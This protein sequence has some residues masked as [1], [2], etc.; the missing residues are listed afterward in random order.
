VLHTTDAELIE[1]VRS[2]FAAESLSDPSG[3]VVVTEPGG[4]DEAASREIAA[5]LASLPCIVLAAGHGTAVAHVDA[6]GEV[7]VA[8]IDD[9][10]RV[11]ERAPLAATAFTLLLRASPDTEA[12]DLAV[13]RGLVAES[14]TYS[15]LQ[16]GP[17]FAAWRA[18]RPR[19]DPSA[20]T[21][22]AVR[23]ERTGARLELVLDRP[24]VRNA[25]DRRLRDGML[26]GLAIASADTTVTDV[27]VRG[28]GPSFCSGGDL[29][30][31]GSFGDPASAHLVRLTASIGR[32]IHALRDRI[33]FEV[34]GPCAG[35]GVELPAFA[36]RVT[37]A[38]DYEA[39]LP[40]V[41][42]GLVP[43][44][45]GTVSLPRRIGR[46]R[47]ALLA[48]SSARIDAATALR[49]GLVDAIG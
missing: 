47:T 44:A 6:A 26:E 9:V 5:A 45:G 34:H 4:I 2:P 46:H 35:S 20:G 32:T 42:L 33:R 17:E 13:D 31:F 40:E 39:V 25:L 10:L 38:A 48:L 12:R 15:M 18:S 30:E 19:R 22:P 41:A 3:M 1:L 24:E 21:G 8:G 11:V 37:A 23:V 29:D 36:H 7:G 49:W 27:V 16:A 14:S 28:A 43:G